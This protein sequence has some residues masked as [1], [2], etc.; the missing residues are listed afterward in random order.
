MN[1]IL[2]FATGLWKVPP[3]SK[4]LQISLQFLDDDDTEIY[5]KATA[6]AAILHL[7]T[8]HSS[9]NRFFDKMDQGLS[10]GHA[11]FAEF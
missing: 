8:V 4:P 2:K 11:G 6:C 10:F 9:K 5:P 3:A 7:R 1:T